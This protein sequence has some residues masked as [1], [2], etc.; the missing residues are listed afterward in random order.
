MVLNWLSGGL[1]GVGG[2]DFI[3]QER[4]YIE[5][6]DSND[7]PDHA[8][9]SEWWSA[10][11]KRNHSIVT[12]LFEGQLKSMTACK[13]CGYTSSRFE[14]FRFLPIQIPAD[15]GQPVQ[16]QLTLSVRFHATRRWPTRVRVRVPLRA[17]VTDLLEAVCSRLP[18]CRLDPQRLICAATQTGQAPQFPDSA[19]GMYVP[20]LFLADHAASTLPQ[21][22]PE[23]LVVFEVLPPPQAPDASPR[24]AAPTTWASL[25]AS[26]PLNPV[27][28]EPTPEEEA[29]VDVPAGLP[30][31]YVV[32]YY[33]YYYYYC[34]CCCCC[35]Y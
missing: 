23:G 24:D 33:Y 3:G 9:A 6:A 27:V 28:P 18:G 29:K 4:K 35:C 15:D 11:L 21:R 13:Q 19:R 25:P 31:G 16:L 12:L 7:R 8:V 14:P 32:Y 22:G 5:I 26:L 10:H 1:A 20:R 2:S 34:C 17:T 30:S